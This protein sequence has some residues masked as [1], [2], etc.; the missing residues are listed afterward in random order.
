M[1]WNGLRSHVGMTPEAMPP[2]DLIIIRH[3]QSTWNSVERWQGQSDPPLSD[4]GHAQARALAEN[5]HVPGPARLLSSDLLRAADT[6]RPLGA[7]LN[8]PVELE[9][10]LR[11]LDVGSWSGLTREQIAEREPGQLDLYFQ[12]KEGWQGGE[13]YAQHTAR[14]VHAADR[15][16][17]LDDCVTCVV[18][19]H[20]GTIR[21]LVLTLLGMDPALRARF[22]DISHVSVTHLISRQHG[23]YMKR[24]N[25]VLPELATVTDVDGVAELQGPGTQ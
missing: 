2:R 7:R 5:L 24:F 16:T 10:D 12:G 9:T 6:A 20:G 22:G 3:A 15:I 18:V 4:A 8:L 19:T 21:A 11:E 25:H 1:R 13:T 23:W 17:A 14:A